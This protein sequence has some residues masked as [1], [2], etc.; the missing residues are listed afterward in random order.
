M[1][2]PCKAVS[3]KPS[4]CHSQDASWKVGHQNPLVSDPQVDEG[5]ISPHPLLS[6][7]EEKRKYGLLLKDAPTPH[8]AVSPPSPCHSEDLHLVCEHSCFQVSC[9][10]DVVLQHHSISV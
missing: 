7:P 2:A 1:V 4:K 10:A 5:S 8:S 6:V 9:R 3:R